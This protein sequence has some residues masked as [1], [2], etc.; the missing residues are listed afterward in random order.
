[1][2]VALLGLVLPS[3]ADA[4]DEITFGAGDTSFVVPAGVTSIEV[5]AI[6]AHGG[7]GSDNGGV[8]GRAARVV[9][10]LP[11]IP[12]E[13]LHAE[14]G[15]RGLPQLYQPPFNGGG[16]GAEYGAPGGGATDLRT[17]A[18][19]TAGSLA[20]R[21]LVAAGGGGGGGGEGAGAGGDAEMAGANGVDDPEAAAGHGGG[22]ATGSAGG[23]GG[24]GG[25]GNV[26][27]GNPGGSGTL[28][29]GGA[30]NGNIAGAGGGGGGGYYGGGGGGTGGRASR[31]YNSPG[32]G[33]GG[34]SNLVPPGGTATLAALTE[35]ARLKITYT[36]TPQVQA[37]GSAA[38]SPTSAILLGGANG[39]GEPVTAH[40]EYGTTTA[41]GNSTEPTLPA[42][43]SFASAV[44]EG[45]RPA[46]TYHYR[47]V[48]N[49]A[50]GGSASSPDQTFTTPAAAAQAEANSVTPSPL[51]PA[52]LTPPA[53]ATCRVPN[54][55]GKTL[56]AARHALRS[57]GCS[58]GSV[59]KQSGATAKDKVVGQVPKPGTVRIAG[60][61]ARI[62]LGS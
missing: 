14:V 32:G 31:G 9:A 20:S 55:T 45:L 30:S 56:P 46:T 34:G 39:L 58:L 52:L 53:G 61:P 1:L 28:G 6:G 27:T 10:T 7:T 36:V 12:G 57:A 44:I 62:V 16:T 24:Q 4:A 59:R 23:S 60:T 42:E 50:S 43:T 5:E 21:L 51:A 54:L 19:G 49:S 8:G 26:L 48:A 35:E 38:L 33:G 15:N 22:P 40:F 47:L 18:V 11:V 25:T 29:Q 3:V 17:G 2:L 41:Y 13:A 37:G